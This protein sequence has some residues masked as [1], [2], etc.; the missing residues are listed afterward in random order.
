MTK[1]QFSISKTIFIATLASFSELIF[2][3]W[4]ILTVYSKLATQILIVLIIKWNSFELKSAIITFLSFMIIK[5]ACTGASNLFGNAVPASI[6]TCAG[7]ITVLSAIKYLFY[8]IQSSVKNRFIS[9]AHII[10]NTD[11]IACRFFY[12]TGNCLY[13]DNNNPVVVILTNLATKLNLKPAGQIMT[14][15][16]NGIKILPLVDL[17]L[18]VYYNDHSHKIYDVRGACSNYLKRHHDIILH[19]DM[20]YY[21]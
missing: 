15:T 20:G 19:S 5:L 1:A 12:D 21:E 16:V 18:K 17:R 11:E 4:S 10:T 9:K 8:Y 2:P 14:K 13:D 7:I 6:A 3:Y